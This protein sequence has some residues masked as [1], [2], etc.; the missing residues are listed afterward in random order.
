MRLWLPMSDA[1]ERMG[2]VPVGVDVDVYDGVGPVP[3]SADEVEFYVLPYMAGSGPA[4]LMR[5]LPMLRVGQT[6]TAGVDDFLPH[7]PDGVTL[8]NARGV[9]DASTAELAVTLMLA[10]LRGVPQFVRGQDRHEWAGRRAESLADKTVLIVGHG[11]VGGAVERRLGGFECDVL[12][13]A[14]TP[15]D[16]VSAISDIADLLPRADVVVLTVPMTS[17]TVCLVDAAFLA[18]MKDGALLVNVARGPV[19]ETDAL[20][21]ELRTGRLLAALDVTDPEPLPADHELWTLPGVLISPH[22]GG[23]SSAFLPRA[24]ALVADQLRRYVSGMPLRNVI[25]GPY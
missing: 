19:V 18:A 5:D 21:A 20:V 3:G 23:N 11:S 10:S 2:G 22:V 1:V 6:L 12:R 25:T 7:V 14:R 9:H 8:C 24:M 13:V 17:E 4:R 16:G 15:R